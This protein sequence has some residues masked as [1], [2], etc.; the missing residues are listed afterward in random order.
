MIP[1]NDLA[2][3]QAAIKDELDRRIAEVL[4]HGQYVMGPEVAEMEHALAHLVDT[5]HCISVSSGT[6][7]L[8]IAL[9]SLGIGPG[10]EV[11]VP[12][13]TFAATAEAVLLAGATP[14]LVDVELDTCNIDASSV[15]SAIG[16]RTKAII[17]VALYGQP[18]DMAELHQLAEHHG[19][20]VIED[21]A[22]SFG[23]HYRNRKSCALSRIGCT[24]FFPSK[25]LGCYGDGGALFT[26]DDELARAFRE[27]RVHGQSGRYHH[28]RLG[29]GG[30]MDTLQ[31]AIILAKLT[32]FEWEIAQRSEVGL[33]YNRLFDGNGIKRVTQRTD[34]TSVFAQYTILV[35]DR[36]AVQRG[37]YE[38]GIPTAVHYPAPL[39]QQPAYKD[40]CIHAS[41]PNSELLARRVLSLPMH[42]NLSDDDQ[43]SVVDGVVEALALSK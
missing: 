33:R 29:L 30:R 20:T 18:A 16:D 28:T 34:R 7:A 3:Q 24:S 17:P 9:M 11:I 41:L 27:I 43:N 8:L 39:S 14:V 19:H 2:S 6:D 36:E 26:D 12:A 13:F 25:P 40:R 38:R 42:A 5:R 15:K 31:C 37:L 23:A 4:A 22:Q 1:F 10:D 32:R 21:A 35:D